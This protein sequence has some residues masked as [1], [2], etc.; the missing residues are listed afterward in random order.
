MKGA[1]LKKTFIISVIFLLLLSFLVSATT[2]IKLQ[3]PDTENLEDTYGYNGDGSANHNQEYTMVGY[4][5][6]YATWYTTY[7]KL[8]LSKIPSDV[9]LV[10]A[11][12]AVHGRST[13]GGGPAG[14]VYVWGIENQTWTEDTCYNPGNCPSHSSYINDIII[15]SS[16]TCGNHWYYM[17]V[18]PWI[19]S[20]YNANHSNVSF[21]LNVTYSV[22]GYTQLNSKEATGNDTP[23]RPYLNIT[24]S[25]PPTWSM[26]QNSTPENYS[27]STPSQFNITWQDNL[28]LDKV[29]IEIKNSK[30]DS[31]INNETMANIEGNIYIFSAILPAGNFSWKS[32]ANDTDNDL[33]SSDQFNFT[34]Q[35]S[36]TNPIDIYINNYNNQNVTITYATPSTANAVLV[37]SQAGDALLWRDDMSVT[38]PETVTLDVGTYEYK[39]NSSGNTNY[40]ANDAG[41]IFYLIVNQPSVPLST[42]GFTIISGAIIVESETPPTGGSIIE[43]SEETGKETIACEEEWTC[44]DWSECV[45]GSWTTTCTDVNNC[46]TS[47]NKPDESQDCVAEAVEVPGEEVAPEVSAPTGL[48]LGLGINELALTLTT[49]FAVII[50][51]VVL[52]RR[53]KTKSRFE[54]SQYFSSET[55]FLP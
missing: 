50:V 9:E 45:D 19:L 31:V 16:G 2:T 13:G 42:G 33:N 12:L 36:N 4:W 10:D 29:L 17:D 41:I 32:H 20:E 52:C 54:K 27:P 46:S 7:Y 37:Y 51:S 6:Y 30:G 35:K 55:A 3:N 25:D 28:A 53:R 43:G 15:G 48:F 38:N 1:M 49:L 23:C 11:V 26:P 44:T 5:S 22:T 40:S 24:Y 39:A 47:V 14:N 8:N 18:T 21:A 34:I